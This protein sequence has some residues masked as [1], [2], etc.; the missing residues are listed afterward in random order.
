MKS[1][2][3]V[4]RAVLMQVLDKD[5]LAITPLNM[6]DFGITDEQFLTHVGSCLESV[7][8]VQSYLESLECK[9]VVADALSLINDSQ[10]SMS[11]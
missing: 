1:K 5:N 6:G 10:L 4:D 11:R 9:G 2:Q 3:L 7:E 8:D